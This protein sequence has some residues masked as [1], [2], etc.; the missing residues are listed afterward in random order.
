MNTAD[1]RTITIALILTAMMLGW[2]TG[3]LAWCLFFGS[4]I[5]IGIHYAEF[6]KL[7]EWSYRPLG[8][9]RNALDQWF[10]VAYEPYRLLTRERERTRNIAMRLR[11]VVGLTEVIP[12]AVIILSSAG[13]IENI[14]SAAK[15]MLQI[16]DKDVGLSLASI[17]RSPPLIQFI[18]ADGGAN[19]LEFTSPINP[20]KSFEA[21]RFDVDTGRTVLL[22][23]D[24]SDLNRLLTM[25]QSFV[26]N[27]SH[28]LRTPL[29]VVTGYLENLSDP[30]LPLELRLPLTEKLNAPVSRMQTLVE[31]LLLLTQLESSPIA[32]RQQPVNMHAVIAAAYDEVKNLQTSDDQISI[33][34]ESDKTILGNE[35]E[36]HSVC[37]NLLSNAIRYSPTGMP[38]SL[39]WCTVEDRVRL[40][41]V[42]QGGGIAKEHI[43]RLTERFYRIDMAGARS[44]GGTGLGLAIVKH[45][46]LR[47]ASQLRIE[48]KVGAGSRFYCDFQPLDEKND[49]S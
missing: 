4:L 13:N 10:A 18:R 38:I 45:A 48:S 47:H 9:P 34:C 3:E 22:I 2:I 20:D 31:D 28:E 8:R 11:E 19:P 17:V 25:R 40:E 16:T 35:K 37:A 29:T 5:W 12:D 43:G 1:E 32:G 30:S 7:R 14:N 26:A 49:S 15:A 33:R 39:N 23:R 21:R 36:L 27:I 41:V 24:I 6:N 44:R 42:D 46:L